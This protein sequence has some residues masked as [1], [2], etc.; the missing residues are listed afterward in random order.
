MKFSDY[1]RL[2]HKYLGSD[3]NRDDF[4]VYITNLFI[5]EPS[6]EA[7]NEEDEEDRYNPLSSYGKRTLEK[8]YSNEDSYPLAKKTARKLKSKYDPTKFYEE[9]TLSLS[10]AVVSELI[11]DLK[12][13]GITAQK[14]NYEKKCA[15]VYYA[16]LNN[17]SEG[18]DSNDDLPEGRSD[19]AAKS[20]ET[21]K[22]KQAEKTNPEALSFCKR[23][24]KEL[25]L[26]P[27]CFVSDAVAVLRHNVR[28][29]YDD[30]SLCTEETKKEICRLTK[31]DYV[32]FKENLIGKCI[33][34]FEKDLERYHLGKRRFLY[35]GGKYL[36]LALKFG[37][38]QIE[39]TDPFVFRPL[40]PNSVINSSLTSYIRE[41]LR[42]KNDHSDYP[43]P[44]DMVWE[45]MRLGSCS[46][47]EMAF[48]T[49]RMIIS[50]IYQMPSGENK[51]NI[52]IDESCLETY[53]D[54]Y[55]YTLLVL[56]SRYKSQIKNKN[57]S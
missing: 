40:F 2:L 32:D 43:E 23:H 44:V 20:K 13:Y 6:T 37:E 4:M 18:I 1:L 39:S 50:C 57:A 35:D 12:K 36:H 7:E 5:K 46:P 45:E 51:Q 11:S 3:R 22:L 19:T 53:E 17:L 55:Y 56:Y 41:Y 21:A 9:L 31:T 28:T 38:M 14:N 47:E 26:L 34:L 30:Y 42:G 48:W 24:E 8:I 15:E 33:D 27:L 25:P 29:L 16:F 54:M 49:M 10:Y 52:F